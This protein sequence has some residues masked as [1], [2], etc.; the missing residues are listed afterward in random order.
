MN[1]YE[2]IKTLSIEE[3][4]AFLAMHHLFSEDS[5]GSLMYSILKWLREENPEEKGEMN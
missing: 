5:Q 2:K 3:M 1:N 4:A